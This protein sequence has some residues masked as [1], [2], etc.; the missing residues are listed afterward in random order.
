M[1]SQQF[2]EK[3][4]LP[5]LNNV[6]LPRTKGFTACMDSLQGSLDAGYNF[7]PIGWFNSLAGGLTI[8]RD[9]AAEQSIIL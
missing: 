5:I 1:R 2:A 6:L 7:Q 3:H 9:I 8:L 4:G